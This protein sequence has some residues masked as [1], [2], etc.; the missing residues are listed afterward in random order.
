MRWRPSMT[1]AASS[2]VPTGAVT[3]PLEVMT[4]ETGSSL[5]ATK[6]RSR[7]VTI[8]TRWP[9][10]SVTG[11]PETWYC[12]MRF[13]VSA[14]E[15]VGVTVIGFVIMPDSDRFTRSTSAAWS[16][17]ERLRWITPMPPS[18][19]M[20]M[21]RRDSVT[22][23][24][25]ADTSGMASEMLRVRWL[26]VDASWGSISEAA[27]TSRTSSKVRPSRPNFS[28]NEGGGG[29][30]LAS[31]SMSHLRRSGGRRPVLG[32]LA[33]AGGACR[34]RSPR[35]RLGSTA[36]RSTGRSRTHARPVRT[37]T[38]RL[39]R[40]LADR[41]RLGL[42]TRDQ[43]VAVSASPSWLRSQLRMGRLRQ[44][45]ADVFALHGS[46][47]GD[48]PPWAV[49]A[50]AACLQR[51]PQA[52]LGFAS[53][54]RIWGL[55]AGQNTTGDRLHVVVPAAR[56]FRDT[57]RVKVHRTRRLTSRDVTTYAELPVTTVS[58]TLI[59]L[60]ASLTPTAVELVVDDALV[61]ALT[62]V[63]LLAGAL[64]R[65]AH[66]VVAAGRSCG[67]R[68]PSGMSGPSRATPRP[69]CCGGSSRGVCPSRFGSWKLSVPTAGAFASILLGRQHAWCW[70]S[71]ATHTITGRG[72]CP[73]I[74][75]GGRSSPRSAGA[76]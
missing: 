26:A 76:C 67:R 44:I 15:V 51:G 38:E 39:L 57:H 52:R 16:L 5:R 35:L 46:W 69:R 23:S 74:T 37:E 34:R 60:A 17:I 1:W 6:R 48:D 9:A 31:C 63:P 54:A 62:T 27:G 66:R 3:R 19:A 18:R 58:R 50:L 64:N 72:S 59:D 43:T 55:A 61:R 42:V 12:V 11:T 53:A 14:I 45:E 13:I 8:P 47:K 30:R 32:R 41:S 2:V 29:L 21:A 20:A 68:W 28:A 36:G 4:V 70:K 56:A 65:N 24:M 7:F 10:P 22:V 33:V 49:E 73:P 71:M 75:N 25:A 40:E